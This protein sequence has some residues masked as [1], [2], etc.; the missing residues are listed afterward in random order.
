MEYNEGY[1]WIEN[2]QCQL[3]I[4]EELDSR[5]DSSPLSYFGIVEHP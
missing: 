5:I 4:N 1:Y 2:T 3:A